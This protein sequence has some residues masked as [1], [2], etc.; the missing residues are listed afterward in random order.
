MVPWCLFFYLPSSSLPTDTSMAFDQG[1][2]KQVQV[3]FAN[4]KKH[5][6]NTCFL[7]GCGKKQ[8]DYGTTP[9]QL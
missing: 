7:R 8:V 4:R 6:R 2:H 5:V 1:W 3:F 9:Q